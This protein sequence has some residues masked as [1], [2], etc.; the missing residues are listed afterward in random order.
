M[1]IESIGLTAVLAWVFYNSPL[2]FVLLPAVL[3]FDYRRTLKDKREKALRMFDKEFKEMLQAV[4]DALRSGYS[5]ENAFKDAQ[6]NMTLIYGTNGI[7]INDLKEMN[8]KISMRIPAE[9]AFSEFAKKHPSEEAK[10][11]AQVFSFARR[12]G[13]E[14]VK[15]LRRTIEKMEDKLEL[16]Q[17]IHTMIASK[18]MEFKIMSF[19]PMG[20][21][22]YVKLSSG[23]FLESMYFNTAG[24]VV[25]SICIGV[26]L[27]AIV[28]GRRIVDIRV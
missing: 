5:I 26:Y 3:F 19:M 9:Q 7:L 13:G 2:G 24:V 1:V 23:D 22:A 15:N 25:M 14:Y 12:L 18:Q 20:I 6:E 21:L 16:K 4:S 17:D 8:A 28:M 11:F 27:L 10:S